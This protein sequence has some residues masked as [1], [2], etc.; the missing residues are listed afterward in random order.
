MQ[1]GV[2]GKLIAILVVSLLVTLSVNSTLILHNQRQV[3]LD[4]TQRRGHE[5]TNLISHYLAHSVVSYD[6]HTIELLLQ[7]LV[8]SPD[9]IYTRVENHRGK[10]MATAGSRPASSENMLQYT[11]EIR[12][13]DE[14]LGH[15][16]L[17]LSTERINDS[18]SARQRNALI[19]QL[20]ALVALLL[21]GFGA[22]SL[23]ILRPLG[24]VT[25][26]IKHNLESGNPGFDRVPLN[27][28]DEFG[29]LAR[30]FNAL[31]DR[32]QF[33]QKKLE[34]RIDHANRELQQAYE[35]L[36]GQ[37]QDLRNMN[38]ELEQ[39]SITDPLTGLY[40]RRYFERLMENEVAQSVR[41]DETISILLIDLDN[42]KDFNTR[43]GHSAGDEVL[44]TVA[45][46]I[47][48]R[49][50]LTDVACRYGGDEFFVL[51]RRAT[52]ANALAVADDMFRTITEQPLT[53]QETEIRLTVSI[54]VA[55][56]PGTRP[57]TT[58]VDFF[59]CAD[60]AL[61][62]CKE[63][64]RNGVVHFSMLERHT[65]SLTQ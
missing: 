41:N 6:Y 50:R 52:I 47:A 17:G 8:R 21:V 58:A 22:V 48:Q 25:A 60:K 59:H 10:V 37:A 38:R 7:D 26:V 57:V 28:R 35:R 63:N 53:I 34:L 15:L 42:F 18:L 5:A 14:L 2:R 39:L 51:C 49:A 20:L 62:F 3:I 1:W 24:L 30:G 31:Q 61:H 4:E 44:R 40:N 32:L 36:A 33:A 46:C 13:N 64:G 23:L 29:D 12:L 16:Y 65:R 55:T 54:G 19:G 11:S 56:I 45:K 43:Y 9:I 27:T